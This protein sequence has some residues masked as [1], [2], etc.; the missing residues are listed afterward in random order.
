MCL[1]ARVFV[2]VFAR[3]DLRGGVFVVC[4][5]AARV[6]ICVRGWARVHT[7]AT[8]GWARVYMCAW[9]GA[10]FI[11]VC[12]LRVCIRIQH[13]M[14]WV[15]KTRAPAPTKHTQ[16]RKHKHANETH[17]HKSKGLGYNKHR[18]RAQ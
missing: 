4:V 15:Q 16:T 3:L 8:R 13:Q 10:W 7:H 6:F 14:A 9:L 12:V 2:F 1:G 5:C 18:A 17:T 11:F